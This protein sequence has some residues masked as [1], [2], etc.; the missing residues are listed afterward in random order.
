MTDD[1]HGPAPKRPTTA[2]RKHPNQPIGFSEDGLLRFKE[3][4]IV[5]WLVG[6][7]GLNDIARREWP[8]GD[9]TQLMQLIGYSVG[10][11]GSLSTSP[12]ETVAAAD[13][14]ADRLL[15]AL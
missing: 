8:D 11:Y 5:S 1:E 3:N 13:A 14:I 12:P 4:A 9:Y 7:H 15:A 2:E 6:E 10:G